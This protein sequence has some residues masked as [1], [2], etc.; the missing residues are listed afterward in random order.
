MLQ[1]N[2]YTHL[3]LNSKYKIFINLTLIFIFYLFLYG[4]T[5]ALCMNKISNDVEDIPIIAESTPSVRYRGSQVEQTIQRNIDLFAGLSTTIQEQERIIEAQ[6]KTIKALEEKLFTKI[7]LSS[8]GSH[9]LEINHLV[10]DFV[11]N[12]IGCPP[13]E[14]NVKAYKNPYPP[15]LK[16]TYERLMSKA[17]EYDAKQ[18]IFRRK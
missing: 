4:N 18:T 16:N 14:A 3:L 1:L 10:T 8:R 9:R 13:E 11:K 15:E 7:N 6:E 2:Y 5:Q 17:R 12:I